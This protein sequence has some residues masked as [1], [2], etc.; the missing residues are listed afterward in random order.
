MLSSSEQPGPSTLVEVMKTRTSNPT[1]KQTGH[2]VTFG[3]DTHCLHSWNRNG[4]APGRNIH[5]NISILIMF[6]GEHMLENKITLWMSSLQKSKALQ[7]VFW[8]TRTESN[9]ETSVIG[10]GFGQSIVSVQCWIATP[11]R[12]SSMQRLTL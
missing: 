8:K 7:Y 2:R 5:D 11:G 6:W 3:T 4:I 12:N 1:N 10:K 9:L